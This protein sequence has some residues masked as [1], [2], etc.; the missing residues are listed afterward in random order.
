MS[1]NIASDN[2]LTDLHRQQLAIVLDQIIPADPGRGKPSAAD[3]DVV[4]FIVERAPES[5]RTIVQELD[6]LDA[7]AKEQFQMSFLELSRLQQDQL[8]DDKR[9]Q[10]QRFLMGLAMHTVTC[11]YQHDQV[12]QTLGLPAR[13]PYPEGFTVERGD[14]SLLDPVRARGSIWRKAT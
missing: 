9:Q 13:A 6:S 11:Y 4:K 8:V 12:R 3:L 1:N 5:L 2:P 7:D 10:N 14:T